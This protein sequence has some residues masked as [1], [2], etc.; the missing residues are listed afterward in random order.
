MD[1]WMCNSA[2]ETK[3]GKG[4]QKSCPIRR[5]EGSWRWRVRHRC[6]PRRTAIAAALALASTPTR[7]QSTSTQRPIIGA[8]A[9]RC[10][11]GSARAST[12]SPTGTVPTIGCCPASRQT[13]LAGQT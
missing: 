1:G 6:R 4:G 12:T 8:R 3:L 2:T 5:E 13:S 7:S 11:S 9:K 10:C